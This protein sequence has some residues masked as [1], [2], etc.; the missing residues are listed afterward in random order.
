VT[1]ERRAA[2][3]FDRDGTLMQ[4][5][6]YCDDPAKVKVF[7]RAADALRQLKDRGFK[8]VVVTN[9]SGIG[10]GYMTEEDYR[11][12]EREFESQLGGDLIDATYFCPHSPE[13]SCVCRKPEPGMLLKAAEEHQIDLTKSYLVGD[14]DSDVECGKRAGTKTILVQTGY[15]PSADHDRPDVAVADVKEAVVYILKEV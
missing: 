9:Q 15:G 2:V 13:E 1:T 11:A 14:K 12:V 3:F 5:A 7:G 4:D 8:I 6:D 10:R